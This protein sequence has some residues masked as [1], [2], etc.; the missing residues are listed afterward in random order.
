MYWYKIRSKY[1]RNLI[2]SAARFY[3]N[4][5][6]V[7]TELLM[8]RMRRVLPAFLVIVSIALFGCKSKQDQPVAGGTAPQGKQ[9]SAAQ[10]KAAGPAVA[11]QERAEVR[12]VAARVLAQ[13]ES[14]DF[15]SLYKE[16]SLGFQQLGS[17]DQFIAKFQQTRQSVGALKNPKETSFETLPNNIHVL[18]YRVSND[19]YNTDMRL[20]FTRSKNGKM[21]LAGLNQHDELKK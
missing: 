18:V 14:G 19:H 13:F 11:P 5:C 12:A 7:F 21:E 8:K 17:E 20:T 6:V 15:S 9:G 2:E 4:L 1:L 3:L 16:A 10:D